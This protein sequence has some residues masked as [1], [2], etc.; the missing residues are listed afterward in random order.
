V[1]EQK[2]KS[3]SENE[4]K[5]RE[6]SSLNLDETNQSLPSLAVS[7]LQEFEHVFPKEMPNEL[8]PI[9]GIEHQIDF[10]P[11]V[12]IP[13]RPAYRSNPE[14]TKELQRQVE[15][16][17][18]KGHVR[19]SMSPCAVSMLLVPK[20]DGTWRMCVD[21]RAINK[22]TVK[23]R[24]PIPRLDDMLHEL[25]RSSIFTKID[26]KTACKTKYGLY[27][28]LV[29]PFGL[30][31]A[32]STF[33]RLINHALSAF[34]GR[35]VVVYF[36]DILVYS[37][38][39]DEHIEHLHC[40]LVVLRKEKLYANLKT[41]SFCL[42]KV[43]FLGYLVTR[44]GLAVDKEKVKAIKE[45]PTPKSIIENERVASQANKGQRRVIFEPGDWVWVHMRKERFPAYRKTKLHPRGDGSFQILEKINDNAHK[46]D[47]PGEYKVSATFTVSDLSPFDVGEDSRSNPF[48][49]R[50]NDGNQSGP[51]LK[52]PLQVPDGPITRSRANKIKEAMQGLVQST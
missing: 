14:E 32:P 2:R 25:H 48:E 44:K 23:Y 21:C 20:K 35:L 3:E 6:S 12:A 29:M 17:L 50:G 39:L 10:V 36:D 26:L 30:T 19:E 9:R 16:L 40:V 49:E 13:K 8:P 1:I 15:E 22:I 4:K 47:L 37:K 33:M 34:Q 51:S 18:A 52:D 27:E 46:V 38:S 11:D 43:V 28:W 45:W 31:N 7:L 24:H 5:E 41:C 42:D